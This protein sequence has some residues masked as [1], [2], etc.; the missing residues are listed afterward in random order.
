LLRMLLAHDALLAAQMN[1]RLTV[2]TIRLSDVGL[3]VLW[4]VGGLGALALVAGL[5]IPAR[6][7]AWWKAD[8]QRAAAER[9]EAARWTYV[10]NGLWTV[11]DRPS[12]RL[13]R[14]G[15]LFGG[16]TNAV[17]DDSCVEPD[18]PCIETDGVTASGNQFH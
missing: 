12:I 9:A 4:T 3:A 6:L 5:D 16:T 15:G 18:P 11:C 10:G 17:T 8:E 13:Y 2:S 1:R 14:S 7:E